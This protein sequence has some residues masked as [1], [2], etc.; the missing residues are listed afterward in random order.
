MSIR[1]FKFIF[2]FSFFSCGAFAQNYILEGFVKDAKTGESLIAASV[3]ACNQFMSTDVQGKFSFEI[4]DKSCTLEINYLAYD[5]YIETIELPLEDGEPFI[6]FLNSSTN[7]L[8]QAVITASKF[9]QRQSE[10]TVSLEIMKPEFFSSTNA[11]AVDKAIDQIPGVDIIDGQANIRGGSGYSYG[12]GSRVLLVI[13]NMPALQYDGG[14]SQWNDVPTENIAQVEILKGASSV[15]Y[16]SSALNGV[17]HFTT[18]DAPMNPTTKMGISYRHFLSPEDERRKWWNDSPF[19]TNIFAKH[20]RKIGKLDVTAGAFGNVLRS[21]NQNVEENRGRFY[22][23]LKYRLKPSLYLSLNSNLS[24]GDNSNFFYW[25][26]ALR[27][28]FQPGENTINESKIT[29]YYFDPSLVYYASDKSKHTLRTRLY[30][31]YNNNSDNQAVNSDFQYINYTYNLILEEINANFTT[32][33]EGLTSQTNAELYANSRYKAYNGAAFAQWNH[34]L[35]NDKVNYTFGAR[36]ELNALNNPEFQYQIADTT[37]QVNKNN[38]LESKPVFRS[39]INYSPSKGTYFRASIGQGYRYPTIAE[40]FTF[41]NAGGL[42]VIPN[43]NLKSETGWS[44][45]VGFRQE[46]GNDNI[47][48]FL[49]LAGFYSRYNNMM[50]FTLSDQLFTGFQARNIGDTRISGFESS[51][52]FSGKWGALTLSG[53][54]GYTYLNPQYINFDEEIKLS[55]TVEENIL[56]YRYRH[57]FKSNLKLDL[58]KWSFFVSQRYNSHM[59][60]IDRNFE[61]FIS[62]I[63]DFRS[64][65]DKGYNVLNFQLG[66]DFK[67]MDIYINLDN[68]MNVLYTERPA[69]LEAPRNISLRAEFE[70]S[71]SN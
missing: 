31:A 41:T 54:V 12:A 47:S 44:S 63:S 64:L 56:K 40:K 11:P 69:L 3:S 10:S 35:F 50:E 57:S 2:L 23:N 66:Y 65:Y 43:P 22:I 37:I 34:K 68:A 28:S 36:Y 51:Y 46:Y 49:D 70:I 9:Q 39:G 1:T 67:F 26:N 29:R 30:S 42:V 14:Y 15:L 17:I 20:S 7:L 27:K 61:Q 32:G 21:Y 4:Q 58:F 6:V 60:S 53:L 45:E 38:A 19:E 48:M 52:G 33:V 71:K 13:D 18:Q 55:G 16:G 24:V 59:I 5:T 25:G 8:N 62:G